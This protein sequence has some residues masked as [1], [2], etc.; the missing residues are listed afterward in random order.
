MVWVELESELVWVELGVGGVGVGVRQELA[1]QGGSGVGGGS[2]W[3][4]VQLG[5]GVDGVGV[6][7]NVEGMD[8]LELELVGLVG[9]GVGRGGELLG[10]EE[11]AE[12]GS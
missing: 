7:Q 9:W 3:E 12:M 11:V 1:T 4:L 2:E 6:G 10:G 8:G 5:V